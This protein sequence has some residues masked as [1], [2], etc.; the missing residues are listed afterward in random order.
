LIG[1][2][3]LGE[4]PGIAIKAGERL[5]HQSALCNNISLPASA[6]FKKLLK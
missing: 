6:Y 1:R 5:I 4:W 3:R 2:S